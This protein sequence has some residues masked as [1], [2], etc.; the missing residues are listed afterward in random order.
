M[1][2]AC[3]QATDLDDYYAVHMHD[4]HAYWEPDGPF[5]RGNLMLA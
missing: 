1:E 2:F 5:L 4:C 3:S